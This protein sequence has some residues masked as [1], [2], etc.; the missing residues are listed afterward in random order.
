MFGFPSTIVIRK[1]SIVV[2]GM[3]VLPLSS[4]GC[5]QIFQPTATLT[6]TSTATLTPTFTATFTPTFT[7][8]STP[9]FTPTDTATPTITL[10]P[11]PVY[12][13]PGSYAMK[14]KCT[15]IS[16]SVS[17]L[18][19]YGQALQSFP[20]SLTFCIIYV[21]V[22]KDYSMTYELYYVLTPPN[23]DMDVYKTIVNNPKNIF[24]TDD[25]K[26]RYEYE[27][28][29][30]C[31]GTELKTHLKAV[32]CEGGFLF[33][34]AKPGATS[35]TFHYIEDGWKSIDYYIADIVLINP[36]K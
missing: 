7:L 33:P 21:F 17:L 3:A 19:M 12:N 15:V 1:L 27:Y 9:T 22:G 11:T 10:T 36:R 35:F 2:V 13:A 32:S 18:G 16:W 8:T 23:F 4:A 20:V 24:L 34:K 25:K 31:V 6:P 26:N 28:Y 14:N 30:G 5:S 29:R